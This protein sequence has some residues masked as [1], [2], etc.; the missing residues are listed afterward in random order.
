MARLGESGKINWNLTPIFYTVASQGPVTGW[1]SCM[2][3]QGGMVMA[4]AAK[5]AAWSARNWNCV[6]TGMDSD[7]PG[8]KSS[9]CSR[10]SG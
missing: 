5:D 7:S 2:P 3:G 1:A 9:T 6:P 4:T 8:C 10:P